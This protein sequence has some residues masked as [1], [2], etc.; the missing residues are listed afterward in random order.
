MAELTH[1]NELLRSHVTALS[2]A[3]AGG[4]NISGAA[5]ASAALALGPR[6]VLGGHGRASFSESRRA[7]FAEEVEPSR[8]ELDR[9]PMA[10]PSAPWPGPQHYPQPQPQPFY[11][12]PAP[13][14]P[15]ARPPAVEQRHATG[16]PRR[17]SAMQTSG[18]EEE[19]VEP[20]TRPS[21]SASR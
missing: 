6:P 11:Q 14:Q 2:T 12:E 10:A 18:S 1:D 3:A 5:A 4:H 16:R 7:S 13:H 8:A 9:T 20:G 19:L 15:A 17:Q 21:P